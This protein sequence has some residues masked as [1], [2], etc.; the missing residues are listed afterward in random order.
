MAEREAED[1]PR[2]LT[3]G[4]DRN[5]GVLRLRL[6]SS[7]YRAQLT[8]G[9][10][11][12]VAKVVSHA[13]GWRVARVVN[14][15]A[16]TGKEDLPLEADDGTTHQGATAIET[17]MAEWSKDFERAKPNTKRPPRH[18][19]HLILSAVAP[20]T[21]DGAA[22]VLA[23]AHE[24][25]R[26]QLAAKG[27]E[28]LAVLHTDTGRPHVHVV[29][30]NTARRV[31]HS[32]QG[33]PP[34][35]R[36]NPPELFELRTR[37]AAALESRGIEQAAT[38]RRDRPAE[39]QKVADGIERLRKDHSY[40]MNQVRAASPTG[41]DFARRRR[42][43]ETIKRMRSAVRENTRA[44]SAERKRLTGAVRD[45]NR[46][47]KQKRPNMGAVIDA[48]VKKLGKDVNRIDSYLKELRE[49]DRKRDKPLSERR[50][51]AETIKRLGAQVA[52]DIEAARRKI[53]LTTSAPE[54]RAAALKALKRQ[55][56]DLKAALLTR[57]HVRPGRTRDR[58]RGR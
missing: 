14:Y 15:I 25:L 38:L 13:R 6:A 45:L 31:R 24:T 41:D 52:R 40:F 54:A 19:T 35:L 4:R 2:A 8:S 57:G 18:A 17:K 39:V 48:A 20:N 23:A 44:G 5:D 46:E 30:K 34:K 50:Q 36:L 32:E 42:Q 49:H 12:A 22:R 1:T 47:L 9:K 43:A 26:P 11:Q 16:R 53:Q 7:G 58:D 51:R 29:I 28:Y 37:F 3:G 27:Y 10:P 56:R 33:K 55:E 21:R